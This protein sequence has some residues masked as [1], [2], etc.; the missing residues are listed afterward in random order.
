VTDRTALGSIR[1]PTFFQGPTGVGQGGWTAARLAEF[2]GVPVT[3]RLRAPVPLETELTV[4]GSAEVG[5][6]CRHGNTVILEAA[7][8]TPDVPATTPVTVAAAR[9]AR[10]A[11]TV[12]PEQHPVPFCFSCGLQ[13]D[14][15]RVH[16]GPLAD[17]PDRYATD[18]T[19]PEWATRPDG[20]LDPAALWAA[21]DCTA[22]WYACGQP[23][24]RQAVTAQFAVEVL[25]PV[26]PGERLAMVAWDGGWQG[27]WDGRKRGVASVAFDGDG[28]V[29]ARSR[30]LWVALR[31]GPAGV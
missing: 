18:W 3:V 28:R 24:P 22:A 4:D 6:R 20:T 27:G 17:D 13:P 15:M 29:V 25:L 31:E 1:I 12:P 7:P 10:D 21:L 5:W 30:S 23:E 16:A 8:W 2:A 14:S 9:A 19:A 26:R 11:F